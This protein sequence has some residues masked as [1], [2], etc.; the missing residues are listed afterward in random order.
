VLCLALGT[1]TG[2]TLA[3]AQVSFTRILEGAIA[4][5]TGLS[6]GCAWGDYDNDG[7][8]DLIVADAWG[9]INRLYHNN[10]DG[11]FSRVTEGTIASDPGDSAAPVW[12]DYDNDGDLDLF[13]TSFDPPRDCFYRNE[14]DGHFTKVTEGAWVT[15]SGRGVGAA[16]GDYD[17][18]GFLDLF[19]ANASFGGNVRNLLYRNTGTGAFDRVTSGTIATD[20]GLFLSCAWGDYDNDGFLD[21]FVGSLGAANALYRNNGDGTFGKV[22]AGSIVNDPGDSS[23]CAWAD[24]DNDGFLDLFVANATEQLNFLYHNDGSTNQWLKIKCVGGPSNRAAIGAKIR[25]Q[26]QNGLGASVWQMREISGGSGYGSQNSL[27]AHF[28]LGS[29]TNAQTIR[30]EWPSGIVQ[31]L[32]DVAAKQLLTVTEPPLLQS[33]LADGSVQLLLTDNLGS[34]SDIEASTDLTGWESIGTVTHTTRTMAFADP[35]AETQSQRF[36]RA[37]RQ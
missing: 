17:N 23:G 9:A 5:D 2:L 25:V 21:L 16:W 18:D 19:V 4:Q 22:T 27:I 15:D 28:G 11:T 10:G 33:S 8:P 14:G 30:I 24:Y 13:V 1:I 26:I 20:T 36:Y 34:S 7:Y 32:A 29:A 6:I 35:S 12:G 3:V 37:V 31:T